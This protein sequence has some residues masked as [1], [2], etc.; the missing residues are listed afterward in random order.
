MSQQMQLQCINFQKYL[1]KMIKKHLQSN[2]HLRAPTNLSFLQLWKFSLI[3]YFQMFS[4]L[5]DSAWTPKY[6]QYDVQN[7]HLRKYFVTKI[8]LLVT[9]DQNTPKRLNATPPVVMENTAENKS[10]NLPSPCHYLTSRSAVQCL[11]FV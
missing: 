9:T 1:L 2:A 10:Q 4:I 6:K 8:R 7:S 5:K 3:T 11:S